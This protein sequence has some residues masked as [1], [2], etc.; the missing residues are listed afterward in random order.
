MALE[1]FKFS[2][3][4]SPPE[5]YDPL[6]F[7]QFL[8]TLELYFS[9]LDA[10]TPNQAKSY[11]ADNFYGDGT[12]IITPKAQ[13]TSVATQTAAS[14]TVGYVVSF[15][16]TLYADRVS[17]V[18]SSRIT[19]ATAGVYNI[20]YSL[21]V[22]NPSSTRSED[23]RVWL[24]K[25]GTT[26]IPLSAKTFGVPA[27]KGGALKSY[28]MAHAKVMITVAAGDYVEVM[29]ATTDTVVNLPSFAATTSPAVPTTPS[30]V[31]SVDFAV[32]V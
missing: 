30:A 10:L 9:Q 5:K 3:L 11:R 23:V 12:G 29:W 2:P 27:H 32:A 25:N 20:E 13:F 31:V 6:F 24:R 14:T 19:F 8:R 22:E 26:N 4:P 17:L 28:A 21:Q 16:A 15:D 18:S 1:L 7:R